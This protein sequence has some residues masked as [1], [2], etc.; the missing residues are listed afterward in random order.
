M[1]VA[2]RDLAAGET[3]ELDGERVQLAQPVARGH[4][5]ALGPIARARTSSNMASRSA[6]RSRPS[7]PGNIFIRKTPKPT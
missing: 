1:A 6:T 3:V 5:F 2:L 4:K 7:G